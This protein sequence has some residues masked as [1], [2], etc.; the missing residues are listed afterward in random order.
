MSKEVINTIKS[1]STIRVVGAGAKTVTLSELEKNAN[2][3][4]TAAAITLALSSTDGVWSV[5]RGDD[6]TGELVLQ[7]VG[8]A[9]LAFTQHDI[10]IAN[11]STANF[12]LNNSGTYGTLILNVSKTASYATPLEEL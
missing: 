11:T 5:Y 4:V 3:T 1:K 7:I 2:E 9:E 8:N 12:Y 10:S 6:N